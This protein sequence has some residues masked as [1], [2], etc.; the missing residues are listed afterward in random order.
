MPTAKKTLAAH[1]KPPVSMNGAQWISSPAKHLMTQDMLDGLVP[2]DEKIQNVFKLWSTMYAHQPE[3]KDFPFEET[4][5]KGRIESLQKSI[6]QLAWAA[7][8]DQQCLEEARAVFPEQTHG[9]TGVPL[10]HGSDADK[11]LEEDMAAGRHL[12]MD[13]SELRAS[14]LEVYGAFSI[15]RFA[16]R[17]D[18]KRE[19][20]KP[21]GA[22]PMQAAAKK[23]KKDEKRVRN[24]P[25]ISRKATEG[26]NAYVNEA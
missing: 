10:W 4:R 1:D 5:Y 13:P 19:M 17:V 21:Y 18:Q 15:K 6:G 26:V 20:A 2:V 24:R 7:R 14:N 25:D 8:R 16:K 3:F 9:P 11:Q 22:N 23:A 12:T